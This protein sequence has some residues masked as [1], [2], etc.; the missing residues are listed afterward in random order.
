MTAEQ[1]SFNLDPRSQGLRKSVETIEKTLIYIYLLRTNW[2]ISEVGRILQI[3][4]QSLYNKIHRYN[5]EK[6]DS[7]PE[8]TEDGEMV[9]ESPELQA[10]SGTD[11]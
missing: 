7:L 9:D 10:A 8:I 3:P 4:R 5:I 2:N 11:R 6:P 1:W